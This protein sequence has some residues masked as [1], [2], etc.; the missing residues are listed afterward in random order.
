MNIAN[1]D[2]RITFWTGDSTGEFTDADRLLSINKAVDD[3]HIMILQAQD[4]DDFD[5]KNYTTE[6]PIKTTTLEANK[7]DYTLPT[8]LVKMKR[9]TISYDGTNYYKMTPFDI[10]QAGQAIKSS[11]FSETSPYYDLHDNSVEVYPTPTADVVKGLKI[12]I[13]REMALY[14]TV[15]VSAGTKSPGFDRQF[16][17]LVPLKASWSWLFYKTKDYAGA[18]RIKQQIDEGE[19]RLKQHYSDKQRDDNMTIVPAPVDY[20]TGNIRVN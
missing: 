11:Y 6:F 3:I 8:D 10:S 4:G 14:T 5:D 2:S 15:E 1:I 7:A 13:S 17:Y 20:D 19:Q 16:H 12:W 18:D 9:L